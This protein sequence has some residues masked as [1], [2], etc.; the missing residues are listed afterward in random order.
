[1]DSN[2]VRLNLSVIIVWVNCL[3]YMT[4]R[5]L[6]DFHNALG[7]LIKTLT[8]A[9]IIFG[10]CCLVDSS[11]VLLHQ[12]SNIRTCNL[13]SYGLNMSLAI[14]IVMMTCISWDRFY[15]RR[16]NTNYQQ[17]MTLYK[18]RL[19]VWISLLC[20]AIFFCTFIAQS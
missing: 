10:V 16:Y 19:C 5:R 4:I 7:T 14:T 13:I 3:V 8:V 11:R 9:D 6:S 18:A 17:V 15:A 12:S 2:T 1:M 20:C